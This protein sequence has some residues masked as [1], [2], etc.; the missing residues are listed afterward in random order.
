MSLIESDWLE[1]ASEEERAA[2]AAFIDH[3]APEIT[4][5]ACQHRSPSGTEECPDCGLRLM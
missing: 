1:Q 3:D 5:P 4:C 2:A